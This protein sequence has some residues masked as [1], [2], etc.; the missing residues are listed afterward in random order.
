MIILFSNSIYYMPNTPFQIGGSQPN[1]KILKDISLFK[2]NSFEEEL[3]NPVWGYIWLNTGILVNYKLLTIND[4]INLNNFIKK[5]INIIDINEGSIVTTENPKPTLSLKDDLLPNRLI[6]N[7]LALKC[8]MVSSKFK[9]A[10]KITKLYEMKSK[11]KSIKFNKLFKDQSNIKRFFSDNENFKHELTKQ[12]G[13][14]NFEKIDEM[15]ES[16][17]EKFQNNILDILEKIKLKKYNKI[18]KYLNNLNNEL[19]ELGLIDSTD[20]KYDIKILTSEF[21]KYL[22]DIKTKMDQLKKYNHSS[23]P[24]VKPFKEFEKKWIDSEDERYFYVILAIMW[25][26][27]T[28]KEAIKEYYDGLIEYNIEILIPESW[29]IWI[30]SKFTTELDL[31]LKEDEYPIMYE[32]KD[33]NPFPFNQ[34]LAIY[35]INYKIPVTLIDYKYANLSDKIVYPDCGASSIRDFIRILI[36]DKENNY[37]LDIL[38]ALGAKSF[39]IKYFELFNEKYQKLEKEEGNINIV[40]IKDLLKGEGIKYVDLFLEGDFNNSRNVWAFITSNIEN[41]NYHLSYQ[42]LGEIFEIKSGLNWEGN[43]NIFNVITFLF[44]NITDWTDFEEIINELDKPYNN[45]SLKVDIEADGF[46]NIK[47]NKESGIFKYN[48]VRGHFYISFEALKTIDIDYVSLINQNKLSKEQVFYLKMLTFDVKKI[49]LLSYPGNIYFFKFQ[50]NLELIEVLNKYYKDQDYFKQIINKDTYNNL[51]GTIKYFD[52]DEL[53]RVYCD[54]QN[55]NEDFVFGSKYV[56]EYEGLEFNNIILI[57]DP[58]R[59]NCSCIELDQSDCE[60]CYFKLNDIYS[61]RFKILENN[62]I[63][64]TLQ[65]LTNLVEL[66]FPEGFNNGNVNITNDLN[67][68]KLEDLHYYGEIESID[69]INKI[70]QMPKISAVLLNT[71]YELGE[72]LKSKEI[73]VEFYKNKEILSDTGKNLLIKAK[74]NKL[75]NNVLNK[76]GENKYVFY[77]NAV[78]LIIDIKEESEYFISNSGDNFNKLCIKFIESLKKLKKITIENYELHHISSGMMV[79]FEKELIDLYYNSPNINELIIQNIRHTSNRLLYKTKHL[80]KNESYNKKYRVKYN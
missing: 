57:T 61:L 78:N 16:L 43:L 5:F 79:T 36:L 22:K 44:R 37:D 25:F 30:N 12:V 1:I 9:F 51:F 49:N 46:G 18:D 26:N 80:K 76:K 13:W 50:N 45:L 2:P 53:S 67:L 40:E 14:F 23:S 35:N 28:N 41:V 21:L 59:V 27:S 15:W 48:F 70:S 56:D 60:I 64:N 71:T 24:K 54:I 47:L 29:D 62:P 8:I 69:E 11:L 38:R 39:I 32:I 58:D 52:I 42:D 66:K 65:Y 4:D 33:Y 72:I 20:S 17:G 55:L 3:L 75:F 74:N 19:Y 77:K 73:E 6:G 68:N 34:L 10:N 7:Y 31:V 63:S